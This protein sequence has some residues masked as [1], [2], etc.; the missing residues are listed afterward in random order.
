MKT[1]QPN[2]TLIV[3][4]PLTKVFQSARGYELHITCKSGAIIEHEPFKGDLEGMVTAISLCAEINAGKF[5]LAGVLPTQPTT[6]GLQPAQPARIAYQ[7][8]ATVDV[9]V[10]AQSAVVEV[11]STPQEHKPVSTQS[12]GAASGKLNFGAKPPIDRTGGDGQGGTL[13]FRKGG[14]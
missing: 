11:A 4:T 7:Q 13:N 6:Q 5:Y 8:P 3:N 14:A 9:Q 1:S 2:Q 10:S 12:S